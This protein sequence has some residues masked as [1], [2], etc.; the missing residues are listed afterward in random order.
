MSQ[1]VVMYSSRFCPFCM[2]AAAV[3][4]SK[5]V[6]Y[7][8]ILVD[9]QPAIRQEMMQKSGRHTVPQI[10]IG[11]THVGGCDDLM[12]LD[13]AGKLDALLAQA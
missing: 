2:R 3:L 10:W 8:E 12:A 11:D 5:G 9:G 13:R 1:S 6:G 7:E 4:R